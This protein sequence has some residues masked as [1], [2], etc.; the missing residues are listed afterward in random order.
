M[1]TESFAHGFCTPQYTGATPTPADKAGQEGVATDSGAW[2]SLAPASRPGVLWESHASR[3]RL[4]P[5]H[6]RMLTA[7]A[8]VGTHSPPLQPGICTQGSLGAAHK[9]K[10][11][12][13]PRWL[14]PQ[15]SSQWK[16]AG[17]PSTLKCKALLTPRTCGNQNFPQE[18]TS[19]ALFSSGMLGLDA[20]T[21]GSADNLLLTSDTC[22]A[23]LLQ[24]RVARWASSRRAWAKAGASS[25]V[26][27]QRAAAPTRT[28]HLLHPQQLYA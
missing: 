5:R 11:V 1:S 27:P 25:A 14:H 3:R 15:R 26:L 19:P 10:K 22:S 4:R 24:H 7:R 21:F 12:G 23:G 13:L 28:W 16:S 18:D 8:L 6:A 9:L 17:F 20:T 2:P